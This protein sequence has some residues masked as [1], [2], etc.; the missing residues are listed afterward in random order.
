[1]KKKV[2]LFIFISIICSHFSCNTIF[3]TPEEFE[4]L[5]NNNWKLIWEENFNESLIDST[6]WSKTPRID[7]A[8]GYA[9]DRN[10]TCYSSKMVLCSEG[11]TIILKSDQIP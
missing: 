2:K 7:H 11:F 8:L 3:E 9:Y 10:D 4:F 6:Y 1:M 5:Q